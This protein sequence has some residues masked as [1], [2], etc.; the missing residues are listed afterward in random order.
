MIRKIA[1]LSIIA[2]LSL[3]INAQ[4]CRNREYPKWLAN[5]PPTV[6]GHC[7][8]K[9]LFENCAGLNN[10]GCVSCIYGW[11]KFA[12]YKKV[13]CTENGSTNVESKRLSFVTCDTK[14]SNNTY[15]WTWK[16]WIWGGLLIIVVCIGIFFMCRKKKVV[17]EDDGDF[18]EGEH[19]FQAKYPEGYASVQ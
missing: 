16:T 18:V 14:H 11:D 15:N 7:V 12:R 19:G 5:P 8:S 17:P 3:N 6:G 4:I 10:R 9:T 2:V 13:P 1:I